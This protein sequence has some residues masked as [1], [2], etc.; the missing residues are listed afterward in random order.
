MLVAAVAFRTPLLEL[1]RRW[2]VQE[3]YSHGFLIPI[4]AAWLVWKGELFKWSPGGYLER[5][6][7]P[8]NLSV[9][10]LTPPATVAAIRAGY[11]PEVHDSTDR[12]KRR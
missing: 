10:L 4:V 5:R 7:R 3:E 12:Q 8:K 6:P 1:V 2:T 11:I 9:L